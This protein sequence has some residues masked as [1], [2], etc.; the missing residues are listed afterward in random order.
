MTKIFA[1][2]TP[3]TGDDFLGCTDAGGEGITYVHGPH[4]RLGRAWVVSLV[5]NHL[6]QVASFLSLEPNS[7]K[8]PGVLHTSP[9]AVE[10]KYNTLNPLGVTLSSSP[11]SKIHTGVCLLDDTS[12]GRMQ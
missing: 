7:S 9:V 2:E 6:P 8:K 12:E 10:V 1:V 11:C 5:L 3:S 4:A